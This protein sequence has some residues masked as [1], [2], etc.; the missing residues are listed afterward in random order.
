MVQSNR[1]CSLKNEGHGVVFSVG[2]CA[3]MEAW[4]CVFV[5]ER[6]SGQNKDRKCFLGNKESSGVCVG[7]GA[8]ECG[9]VFVLVVYPRGS[10]CVCGWVG[11][12]CCTLGPHDHTH[13]TM[14]QEDLRWTEV[15]APLLLYFRVR[16]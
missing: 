12:V 10:V 5:D 6:R 2:G 11:G 8:R 15:Q 13:E 3:G 16:T 9:F 14:T 1:L 4:E 7:V